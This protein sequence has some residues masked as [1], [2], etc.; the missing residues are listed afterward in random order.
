MLTLL[1]PRPLWIEEESQKAHLP[2]FALG[3][4]ERALNH[5]Y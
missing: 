5:V 1:N 4:K 2:K 3:G